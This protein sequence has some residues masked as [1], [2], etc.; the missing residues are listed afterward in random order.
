MAEKLKLTR[1]VLV[2][3]RYDKIMLENLLDATILTT[4]GFGIFKNTEK[5]ALLRRIAGTRGLIV[6]V[7][8]DGGGRQIRSYLTGLLPKSGVTHLYIPPVAGKESRKAHRSRAGLLGVEGTDADTLRALFAPYAVPAAGAKAGADGEDPGIDGEGPGADG[9]NSGA[10]G[11]DDTGRYA[12]SGVGTAAGTDEGT[13]MYTK[14]DLYERGLLG[15]E[16][17]ADR[18]RAL[19]ARLGLPEMSSNALLDALNLLGIDLDAP[20][21][22]AAGEPGKSPSPVQNA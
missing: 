4:E 13:R 5:K 15:G 2:E 10:D 7:D 14:A 12:A 6:L 16:G 8:S 19:E 21:E 18:R 9:E 11:G 1:A 20:A 22:N 17:S 3:G